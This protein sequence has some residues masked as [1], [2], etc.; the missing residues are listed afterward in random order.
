MVYTL[1]GILTVL[2]AL[3]MVKTRQYERKQLWILPIITALPLF[4]VASLRYGIGSDFFGYVELFQSFSYGTIKQTF[5]V[6]IE[7][8]FY[9]MNLLISHIFGA[10][11]QW[12]FVIT[13]GITLYSVFFVIYRDSVNPVESV[14]LYI[15]MTFYLSSL[16]TTREHMACSLLLIALKYLYE[17]KPVKFSMVVIVAGLFHYSA[18]AFFLVWFLKRIKITPKKAII[19]T[20]AFFLLREIVATVI[21]DVLRFTQYS[22]YLDVNVDY[23]VS[24]ILG[25]ILQLSI[26][27]LASFFFRSFTSER[28][29]RNIR[30]F[31]VLYDCQILAVCCS[32]LTGIV[33]LVSR[34]KWLFSYPSILLI[35]FVINRIPNL[36]GRMII[37]LIIICVFLIYYYIVIHVVGSYGVLP[38]KSII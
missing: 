38:Y 29:D 2:L 1:S 32:I 17:N 31:E 11:Y 13:S 7:P 37:K 8:L 12:L 10:N 28:D 5:L 18:L 26:L 9:L 25:L 23:S 36:R 3:L 19:L 20:V 16:N 33:P 24:G 4:L 21:F 30:I 27:V 6:N 22:R 34:V 14:F 15:S 35:P